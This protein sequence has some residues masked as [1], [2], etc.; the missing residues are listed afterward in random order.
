METGTFISRDPLGHVDGPNVYCYVRQNPWTMW[1]PE[2]LF[3][4]MRFSKTGLLEK[5]ESTYIKGKSAVDRVLTKRGKG[6]EYKING[7]SVR[8]PDGVKPGGTY[9]PS[10]EHLAEKYPN[11]VRFNKDG[12]PDFSPYRAVNEKG[13]DITVKIAMT[14]DP[15]EDFRRANKALN[16]KQTPKN[17]SWHHNQ[18]AETMELVHK[19]I[20]ENTPHTGG[21]AIVKAANGG[22]SLSAKATKFMAAAGVTLAPNAS[23][24][25]ENGGSVTMGLA[26]DLAEMIDVTGLSSEFNSGLREIHD[27][28][29]L[30]K[31]RIEKLSQRFE[32][33]F[34]E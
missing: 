29:Q 15:A 25:K 24:A 34:E 9:I 6:G 11:G 31:G 2:G 16:Y 33:G 5:V 4:W 17:Y 8:L 14:G 28:D 27:H 23:F 12:F 10:A 3:P 18:D 13:E 7:R 32:K 19:D 21:M 22:E 30:F 26:A 1:D 20:H